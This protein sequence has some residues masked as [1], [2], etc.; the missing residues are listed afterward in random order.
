M[1]DLR[2]CGSGEDEAMGRIKTISDEL[3]SR[4]SSAEG[5]AAA[6]KSLNHF[7]RR[8]IE[9][10]PDYID[11]EDG[12]DTDFAGEY[13]CSKTGRTKKFEYQAFVRVFA[14]H[15][16]Q[17]LIGKGVDDLTFEGY[18][19]TVL[20]EDGMYDALKHVN[21]SPLII[22]SFPSSSSG[23]HSSSLEYQKEQRIKIH[24]G[25]VKQWRDSS[26]SQTKDGRRL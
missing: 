1:S 5:G 22:I 3:N 15:I 25:Q 20:E 18:D 16:S 2:S 26:S 19:F 11:R 23:R 14:Q 24:S 6:R 10:L 8:C 4:V 9:I 12:R 21:I 13:V 17:W 7:V